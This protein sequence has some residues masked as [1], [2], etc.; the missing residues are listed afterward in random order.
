MFDKYAVMGNPVLHS[1]SPLIHQEF[2]KLTKQKLQYTA[3]EVPTNQFQTYL[4]RFRTD[5][6]LGV[7]VTI[8]FK[9]EAYRLATQCNQLAERAEAVNTLQ[10]KDDAILGFNT[11]G[12]GLVNDLQNNLNITISQR[13][14]LI[15]GAGGAV[16]GVLFPLLQQQPAEILI[17][18]RTEQTARQLVEKFSRWGNVKY[19]SYPAIKSEKI[20]IIINGTS[21]SLTH[22]TLDLPS[23]LFGE[24][25]FCY[26]MMYSESLTTFLSQSIKLGCRYYADGIGMLVEQAAESFYIWRG[27]RPPTKELL[28]KLRK[29]NHSQPL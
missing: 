10:F 29:R 6:G 27:I 2:A 20:D 16:R 19:I 9:Q 17:A 8:P 1:K 22:E 24:T 13:R 3:I 7:N 15:L 18:N 25:T 28:E 23:S 4:Q 21:A 14:I 5:G 26:D 12:L 11:D